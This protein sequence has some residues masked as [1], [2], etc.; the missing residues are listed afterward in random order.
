[1]RECRIA[2]EAPARIKVAGKIP[3]IYRPKDHLLDPQSEVLFFTGFS[4]E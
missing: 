2:R 4:H 3:G 1:M